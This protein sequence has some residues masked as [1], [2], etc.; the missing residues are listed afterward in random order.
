MGIPEMDVRI[1]ARMATVLGL[2]I[3]GA[4]GLQGETFAQSYPPGPYSSGPYR[5]PGPYTPAPPYRVVPLPPL[6]DD[7][8]DLVPLPAPGPYGR[9]SGAPYPYEIQQRSPAGIQSE[10][11]PPPSPYP[12]DRSPGAPYPYGAQQRQPP[13]MQS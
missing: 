13:G 10:A 5:V 3:L 9:P 8:D 1:A 4:T 7:D 2:T 6:P 11:L 12:Y